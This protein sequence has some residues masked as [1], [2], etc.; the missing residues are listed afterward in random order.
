VYDPGSNYSDIKSSDGVL[1]LV[2]C[3]SVYPVK[4]I[5]L[6]I[7]ALA[8]VEAVKVKWVHFGDGTDYDSMYELANDRLDKKENIEFEFMGRVENRKVLE[9]YNEEKPDCIINTSFSEGST[10]SIQEAISFGMLVIATNV[11]G[12]REMVDGNGIL[13]SKDPS[14][15]EI[16]Q[17]VRMIA[18]KPDSELEIMKSRSVDIWK[19]KFDRKKNI[20]ELGRILDEINS[21]VQG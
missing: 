5:N 19:N 1:N 11:G 20:I 7:E 16:A 14:P 18:E 4:R 12:N 13:L 21:S 2:S 17:A 9:Y 6:I 10:V 15:D 3:S 8:L